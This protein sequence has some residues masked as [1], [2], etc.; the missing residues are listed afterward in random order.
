MQ[1]YK[2]IAY[3][4]RHLK[5]HDKIYTTRDLELGAVVFA[6]KIWRHYLYG[7]KCVIYTDHKSLQHIFDQ[8]MLNMRQKRWVELLNDYD[9]EICYHP[10]KVNVM[11]DALSRK[12]R[13]KP[14]RVRALKMTMQSNLMPQIQN[15]QEEALK[16]ANLE[17]EGLAGWRR[18]LFQEATMY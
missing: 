18:N 13:I 11:A 5:I 16:E 7:T 3:T 17:N 10:G 2:V 6:L 14:L 4:S 15:A 12:E 1:R 9:C 8:K